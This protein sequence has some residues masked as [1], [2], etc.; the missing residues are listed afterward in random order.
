MAEWNAVFY[1]NSAQWNHLVQWCGFSDVKHLK[2]VSRHRFT[3][4]VWPSVWARYEEFVRKVVPC[5]RCNS[6]QKWL[7]TPCRGRKWWQMELHI[8]VRF[9]EK[10]YRRLSQL[11]M[12]VSE[13]WNGRICLG[14][15]PWPLC[16]WRNEIGV[17]LPQN[18]SIFSPI[19][20]S[21]LGEVV[22][23]QLRPTKI[24][25]GFGK[26]GNHWQT[27]SLCS[28]FQTSII[29]VLGAYT[30]ANSQCDRWLVSCDKLVK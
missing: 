25:C 21:E 28:S 29:L 6:C 8:I 22:V 16:N 12:G 19:L 9:L 23:I 17:A 3:T 20:Y 18:P 10:T 4:S 27:L 15:P 2:Y 24:P 26:C 5:W 7:V 11:W 30:F 13:E 1:E 14:D